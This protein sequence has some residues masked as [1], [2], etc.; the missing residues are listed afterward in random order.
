M[1]VT[2]LLS[3]KTK[4]MFAA[5]AALCAFITII[6]S[7]CLLGDDIETLRRKAR[8]NSV[9]I[10][11]GYDL[12]AEFDWLELNAQD[13]GNYIM[14][15]YSDTLLEPR[16]LYYEGKNITVTLIGD[17]KE[18]VIETVNNDAFFVIGPEVKLILDNNITLFGTEN[19]K[20]SIVC[21]ESGG[22]LTMRSGSKITGNTASGNGGGVFVL[23]GSF[24]MYGGIIS[25]NRS[26]PYN[27]GGV[28]VSGGTMLFGGGIISG[29]KA[30]SGGGVY[31]EN[32]I[33]SMTGGEISGNSANNLGGGI[34]VR[35]FENGMFSK[36]RGIIFGKN[37]TSGK[38]NS[39]SVG[40]AVC[41]EFNLSAD[42]LIK[43]ENVNDDHGLHF[44]YSSGVGSGWD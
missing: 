30:E 35:F 6:F 43:E 33:F 40:A 39:A 5:R 44:D 29:N 21:V 24:Y 4:L 41:L 22:N 8:E 38:V 1:R 25:D 27:G 18:R 37:E 26:T 16:Y 10:V 23:G 28:Y 36:T 9:I 19:R 42:S 14:N 32:G 15:V 34:Y 7:G 17:N 11:P 3:D 13:G 2:K 20:S 31:I 12:N